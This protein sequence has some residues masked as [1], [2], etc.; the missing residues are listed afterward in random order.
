MDENST[1]DTMDCNVVDERELFVGDLSYFCTEEDLAHL[2]SPIGEV[3]SNRIRRS[4]DGGHS[5]MHAFVRMATP[6]QAKRVV[7]VCHGVVFLGRQM[8]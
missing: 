1:F 4:E 7:A 8:R 5:L 6:D 3:V 2:F